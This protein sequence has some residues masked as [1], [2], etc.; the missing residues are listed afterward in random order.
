MD[1]LYQFITHRIIFGLICKPI[2]WFDRHI[3][4]GT[5]NAFA[6]VT[7][8]ASA[9][10]KGLQSGLVQNYVWAYFVGALLLAVITWICI[11]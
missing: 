1:E 11:I 8:W 7:H 6:H 3:I 9:Q 4:D 5:M 10:I 2:A